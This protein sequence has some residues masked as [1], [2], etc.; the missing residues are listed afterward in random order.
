MYVTPQEAAEYYGVST[1]TL[2]RWADA[3]TIKHKATTGGHRRYLLVENNGK[4]RARVIY[5]R[6]ESLKQKGD[7]ERQVAY[8]RERYPDHELV[9]DIGTGID[10]QRYGFR[11]I[12]EK[13]LLGNVEEVIIADKSRWAC[14]GFEFHE[15]LL[16]RL[17]CN[18][19]S[20]DFEDFSPRD[21]LSKDIMEM[22]AISSTRSDELRSNR[23]ESNKRRGDEISC[24]NE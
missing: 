21:E 23:D 24:D 3:G 11:S 16:Q 7:L 12:L 2:R 6:V 20:L 19:I 13:A 1:T 4:N 15:W 18:L 10:L 5:A 17:E 14:I 22:A 8:L 9:K